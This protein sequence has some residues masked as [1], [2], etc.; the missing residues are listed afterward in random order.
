MLSSSRRRRLQGLD[1]RQHKI[2][3]DVGGSVNAENL[4][5]SPM[6][7]LKKLEE[8]VSMIKTLTI[9]CRAKHRC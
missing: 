8:N 3:C 9:S 6:P 1:N 5:K 2:I 4:Q 7:M